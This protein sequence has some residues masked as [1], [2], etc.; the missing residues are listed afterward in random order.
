MRYKIANVQAAVEALLQNLE[1]GDEE[2][3]VTFADRPELPLPFTSDTS[4]IRAALSFVGPRGWTA[5]FD[6]VSLPFNKCEEPRT[7]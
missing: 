5:L 2:F 7:G 4:A 1:P 3:L 6:A